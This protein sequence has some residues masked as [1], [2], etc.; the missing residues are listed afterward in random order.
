M[1][2]R[3]SQD[4]TK[5]NAAIALKKCEFFKKEVAFLGFIVS[6]NRIRIDLEKIKAIIE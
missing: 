3:S 4:L 2:I 5:Q 1:S 6:V